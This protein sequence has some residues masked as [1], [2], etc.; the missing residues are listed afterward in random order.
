MLG[1]ETVGIFH[2]AD[3]AS[4]H[5]S[6]TTTVVEIQSATSSPLD[7]YLDVDQ[8]V[9]LAKAHGCDCVHPGYGFLSENASFVEVRLR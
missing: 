5:T 3:S 7:A 1:I 4:L 2:K 6:A 8:L 9:A